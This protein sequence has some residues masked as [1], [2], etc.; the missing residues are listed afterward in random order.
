MLYKGPVGYKTNLQLV[1]GV[2]EEAVPLIFRDGVKG[3]AQVCCLHI[4]IYKAQVHRPP[5]T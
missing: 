4:L 5:V 3:T 2:T 1:Y